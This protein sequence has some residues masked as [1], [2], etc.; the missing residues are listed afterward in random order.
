MVDTLKIKSDKHPQGWVLINA[1]DYDP[2]KHRR[3]DGKDPLP[4]ECVTLRIAVDAP[5]IKAVLD[6]AA[7]KLTEAQERIAALESQV[8]AACEM[9]NEKTAR[10]AELEAHLASKPEEPRVHAK[11]GPKPKVR[12]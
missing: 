7:A 6:E 12:V 8:A 2:A 10:I 9:V 3:L 11:P 4:K 1:E 5:E